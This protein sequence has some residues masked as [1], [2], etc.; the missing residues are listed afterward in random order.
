MQS[1]ICTLFEGQYH[2][3]LAALTNSLYR[4]GFRG[5]IYAGYRGT[6]PPWCSNS[7]ENTLFDWPGSTTFGVAEGIQIHFLPLDTDYHLTNYK[8]D[9]MLRLLSGPASGAEAIYYLD[10]DIVVTAPWWTFKDWI[11]C[12]IALCEDVNSPLSEY[13][14]RRMGWRNYY[15]K[16]DI[17][18]NF[19]DPI[20]V[21]GGFIGISAKH[22]D[23]LNIWR[24]LQELLSPLI[25]G[26]DR[27]VIEGRNL[28]PEAL[29]N[30]FFP[31]AKVDQDVLNATIEAW[32]GPVSYIGKEGMGF[33]PG[34]LIL[35]HAVGRAKPWRVKFLKRSL[36]GIIP[37]AVDKRYWKSVSYPIKPYSNR[38]IYWKNLTLK[39]ASLIGRFYSSN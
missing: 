37:R 35:P 4:K 6:L 32:D 19:K 12:G 26:L 2:Y 8:P 22:F 29:T 25:G 27:T 20:Y 28:L 21:N 15:A 11:E 38:Y 14:P 13:H 17:V 9:F 33:G 10:P 34:K 39:L 30:D 1:V 23:F 16:S 36:S 5:S 24:S 7:K 31:F 18:L 3:G